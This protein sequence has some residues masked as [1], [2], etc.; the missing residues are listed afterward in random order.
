LFQASQGGIHSAAG[1]TRGFHDVE[2][3]A[4]ARVDGL[5]NQG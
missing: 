2:T 5:E 4:V 1:Q 3:V